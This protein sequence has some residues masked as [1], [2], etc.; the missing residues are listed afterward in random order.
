MDHRIFAAAL[1]FMALGFAAPAALAQGYAGVMPSDQPA[2][3][4]AG[5]SAMPFT[6]EGETGNRITLRP[7]TGDEQAGGDENPM[8]SGGY[9]MDG[10]GLDEKDM[11]EEK[12]TGDLSDVYGLQTNNS[13]VQ[14][15]GSTGAAPS[16]FLSSFAGKPKDD[17]DPANDPGP[18]DMYRAMEGSSKDPNE[19]RRLRMQRSLKAA[20]AQRLKDIDNMNAARMHE[21]QVKAQEE[22]DRIRGIQ[23]EALA[24]VREAQGTSEQYQDQPEETAT[25]GAPEETMS[26]SGQ[27]GGGGADGGSE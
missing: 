19:Q 27:D 25:D 9:E 15:D 17:M 2:G 24:K 22:L 8:A 6:I 5:Q 23:E 12:E 16:G 14:E 4:G 20:E 3:Q 7:A 1:A 26:D 13:M 21:H 10:D 11:A 18:T